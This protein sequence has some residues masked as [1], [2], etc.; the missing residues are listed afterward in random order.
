MTIQRFSELKILFSNCTVD[1]SAW[2]SVE[3]SLIHTIRLAL[4]NISNLEF[5]AINCNNVSGDHTS[6]TVTVFGVFYH[7]SSNINLEDT[8]NIEAVVTQIARDIPNFTC[9]EIR[10]EHT[11][12]RSTFKGLTHPQLARSL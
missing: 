4:Y 8:I 11:R 9:A 2:N 3:D 7:L 12:H 5:K 10:V 6:F 1:G